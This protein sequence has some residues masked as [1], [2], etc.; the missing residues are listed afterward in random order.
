[1]PPLDREVVFKE[2]LI[3]YGG[4][5]WKV[6]RA[7]THS[8]EDAQDLSQEISLQ[9]WRSL[10][11]FEQRSSP[12]TWVY[13]VALNTG[14][15]WRRNRAADAARSSTS[16]TAIDE[17]AG[18]GVPVAD[19]AVSEERIEQLYA[20]IR[21]LP[22]ADAALVLLSLDGLSYR[23]ISEIVGLSE[24]HVGVKLCRARKALHELLKEDGDEL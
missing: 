1:M 14:L 13:R 8:P 18:P 20:A 17:V 12:A 4:A 3:A 9:L 19:R 21:Q 5:I 6:A 15:A 11:R 2:W 24:S 22:R 7:Y 23:E 16:S 10:P